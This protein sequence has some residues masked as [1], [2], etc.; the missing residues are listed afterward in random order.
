[1]P[2]PIR[3][4]Q[5]EIFQD[6][7]LTYLNLNKHRFNPAGQFD[8]RPSAMDYLPL[9]LIADKAGPP[10]PNRPGVL[11]RFPSTT[12]FVAPGKVWRKPSPRPDPKEP[13]TVRGRPVP[14]AKIDRKYTGEE[15]DDMRFNEIV[16]CKREWEGKW[17]SY[18]YGKCIRRS[19]DRFN[20]CAQNG[21][22][23][24]DIKPFSENDLN[25]EDIEE[26][27]R[28]KGKQVDPEPESGAE[29]E[30]DTSNKSERKLGTRVPLPFYATQPWWWA[31]QFASQPQ[32][33]Q[34]L[35]DM[36]LDR[37]NALARRVAIPPSAYP[38]GMI[39][40]T[41]Y[42]PPPLLLPALGVP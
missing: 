33:R 28:R 8:V 12:R 7:I 22:Y 1:M 19:S 34:S 4:P 6:A 11:R 36:S 20:H 15:C 42:S 35:R 41:P 25:D 24:P 10:K 32:L 3:T 9:V 13:R 27:R 30:K 38:K 5:K 26:Y 31:Y 37:M 40:L 18:A 2:S 17:P 16:Q 21:S 14:P 39:P 29:T 23:N